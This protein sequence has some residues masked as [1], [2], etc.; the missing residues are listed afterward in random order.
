MTPLQTNN[1]HTRTV[2]DQ[3]TETYIADSIRLLKE[4]IAIP[5][6][7]FEEDRVCAHICGFLDTCGI[8]FH[9]EGNNI[10]ALNR[11]FDPSHDSLML[12]AHI[13]T[14]PPAGGY[15]FD[16]Y[17]PDYEAAAEVIPRDSDGNGGFVCG[18]GSNDDGA[19]VVAMTAAFRHFYRERLP[20][21]LILVLSCEEERSGKGGMDMVWLRF[22]RIIF[23]AFEKIVPEENPEFYIH[24]G[25]IPRFRYPEWAVIGE[26]TGMAAATSERGLLVIDAVAEG[27]SG[28][29]ARNEGVN[30][31]DIA[32]EDIT[33]LK[34]HV[35]SKVSGTMGKVKLNVTQINAGTAHNV[36]PDR[37]E[38]VIDIRPTE[39]YSNK[40]ILDTLQGICR[41]RLTARNLG[42]RSS[43]TH[44][45]SPLVQATRSLG[46]P[47]FSSPTTSDWMRIRCDAIKMGPGDSSRSHRKDEFVHVTEIRDAVGTYIEFIRN[48]CRNH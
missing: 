38:F 22:P 1:T 26:P 41:S 42:N 19:S 9:R 14:V 30:A 48:F 4:M 12:N 32:I 17:M 29:A 47:E 36:I 31:I 24:D 39:M 43:A 25:N 13:D 7:S 27:V 18:L 35:F 23:N 34:S 5:S 10:I 28:H 40:E 20:V 15:S 8:A 2:M 3:M 44:P 16:P 33:R 45:G 6:P 21:N 11:Y 46:I 37:C